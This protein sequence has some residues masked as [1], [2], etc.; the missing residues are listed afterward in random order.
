MAQI[1]PGRPTADEHIPYYGQYIARVGDGDIIAILEG[2]LESTS[3]R[4]ASLSAEEARRRLAPDEWSAV[5]VIGHLADVERVLSYRALRI[6]RGDPTPLEGVADFAPY[7]AA[8]GFHGRAL[9]DV[10]DEYATA[11]R[12][13]LALLRGLTGE[14]WTRTGL[15]DGNPISVRALAYILAG[16]EVG[17]LQSLYEAMAE[18]QHRA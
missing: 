1:Q 17:H 6:A 3:A 14:D 7:V 16:H 18:A 10:L 2:Q 5:E 12:A 11:R 9:A 4:M 15:A 13:T 8:G